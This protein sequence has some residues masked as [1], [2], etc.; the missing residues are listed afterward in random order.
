MGTVKRRGKKRRPGPAQRRY[1][2]APAKTRSHAGLS[3]CASRHPQWKPGTCRD[4]WKRRTRS[5][6]CKQPG[7]RRLLVMAGLLAVR[8]NRGQPP[9][10]SIPSRQGLTS[11]RYFL[12][13]YRD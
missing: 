7:R 13:D 1:T 2:Q 5:S 11:E 10:P 3:A 4:E 9:A 6:P 12:F 8:G